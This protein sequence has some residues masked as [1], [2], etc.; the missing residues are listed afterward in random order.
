MLVHSVLVVAILEPTTRY[1]LVAHG[2]IPV[3]RH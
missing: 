2:L 1:L 3:Q